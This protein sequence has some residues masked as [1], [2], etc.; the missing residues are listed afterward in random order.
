MVAWAGRSKRVDTSQSTLVEVQLAGMAHLGG[1]HMDR[2]LGLEA[3]QLAVVMENALGQAQ[4]PEQAVGFGV[5]RGSVCVAV[6]IRYQQQMN[7]DL[8]AGRMDRLI[9]E[10]ERGP[11][12][13][14]C[15]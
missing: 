8:D 10:S 11:W 5:P 12:V 7:T 1:L 4:K 14:G 13:G 3:L 9:F 15:G 6:Q 2:P